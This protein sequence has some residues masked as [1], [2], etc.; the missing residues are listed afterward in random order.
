MSRKLIINAD[1]FGLCQ[2]VNNAIAEAHATGVL[3]S[4][5]IMANM[6]AAD[7]AIEMAKKM[8][9][10]GVG[11]HL[12]ILAGRPLSTD[13]IVKILTNGSGDFKYSTSKLAVMTI[14]SK[15]IRKAIEAELSAQ[16][17]SLISK[18]ITPTHLDSHK[19]FHCLSP[20][21]RIVCSLADKF[22]I[23]AVR[24]PFEPQTLCTGDWPKVEPKDKISAFLVRQMALKCQS[25][26][27]R[28]IKTD[29][30]FGVAHTGRIDDNFWAEVS[31]TQFAGIAEVMT[32]PGYPGGLGKTRLVEQR[33]TE[34][35][36]LCAASTKQ[37]I[38]DAGIELTNYATL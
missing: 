28:F 15:K 13:P 2:G 37:I 25:I 21:W 10:L 9:T 4:A 7:E 23:P 20:I 17:S 12:N 36:W 30:F 3:T 27:D 18:G 33:Q 1:D 6:P 31:Q 24:W 11:V 29:I 19:H 34:L 35:K 26:D 8:P 22:N 32:H 14:A 5:T 16:I 38:A